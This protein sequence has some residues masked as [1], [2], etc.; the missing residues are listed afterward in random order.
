MERA[1]ARLI[2]ALARCAA[3][4]LPQ[5]ITPAQLH[6]R[7]QGPAAA[8]CGRLMR[9]AAFGPA[10]IRALAREGVAVTYH[11]DPPTFVLRAQEKRPTAKKDSLSHP[12]RSD[13]TPAPTK[14]T[15]DSQPAPDGPG[16]D[17]GR[18]P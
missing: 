3:A 4:R 9:D 13:D 11:R 6:R 8:L 12:E 16:P 18:D 1:T 7:H 2:D 14:R 5:S 15:P 17:D 10:V